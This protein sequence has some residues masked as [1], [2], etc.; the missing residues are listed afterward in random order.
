MP[1]STRLHL[2]IEPIRDPLQVQSL[3]RR[4]VVQLSL[5]ALY[6]TRLVGSSAWAPDGRSLVYVSNRAGRNNLWR[7]DLD[8]QGSPMGEPRQ[9]TSSD[10]RQ[11]SPVWSPDGRTVVFISDFDGDE[12]WDLFA[13]DVASGAVEN[14]TG[15]PDIA[16][17]SPRWSPDGKQLV[18]ISKPRSGSSFEIE[19][20]DWKTRERRPVTSNTPADWGNFHPLWSPDGKALVYLREHAAGKDSYLIHYD[21]QTGAERILTPHEGEK[22]YVANDWSPD[23]KRL[24]ITSNAL[25]GHDNVALLGVENGRIAWLTEEE[26]EV[27]GDSFTPDGQGVCWSANVDGH[28]QIYVQGLGGEASQLPL[29]AGMNYP[30]GSDSCFQPRRGG[31]LFYH[32]GPADAGDLWLYDRQEAVRLTSSVHPELS[33]PAARESMVE[34]FLVHFPSRDGRWNLSALLYLPHNVQRDGSHPGVVYIHGGPASQ[35]VN[36]FNRSLQYLVNRGYVVIA[37][38]YRGSTGYGKAFQDANYRDLG[39]GDLDD[40][41]SAAEFLCA[42]GYVNRKKLISMGGSYGGYLTMLAVSKMAER[43]AAGV[44]IVPFVNWFTELEHEDPLLRQYDLATMGDPVENA[45]LYRD[46]SPI[47]FVDQVRCPVL[48]IAGAQDPRC[49]KQEA[50]QVAAAIRERGGTAEL[51]IFLDEGHGFA[52]VENQI[53]AYRQVAEF[54]QRHVPA[55]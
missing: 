35:S 9:L 14:L 15:T 41:W 23:G 55:F 54:L 17:Q 31:L 50:E 49:P 25:N 4:P 33:T 30:T 6:E 43:W 40:V 21:F 8:E 45:A 20:L 38:N 36:G 32:T 27:S 1:S 47:F 5:P 24:L 7:L 39:G 11:G 16:E 48:L 13:L 22:L 19:L 34:P 26:W 51:K 42:T 18:F 3:S 10:Q 44:A 28:S 37:P 46:R 2:A 29:P 12:Q 53:A 52:K